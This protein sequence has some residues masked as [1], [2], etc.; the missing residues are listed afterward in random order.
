[1]AFEADLYGH[2]STSTALTG[3]V[4]DRI[5]P[6]RS[7]QNGTT[8]VV[9]YQRISGRRIETLNTGPAVLENL[10]VRFDVYTTAEDT[11]REVADILITTLE[12]ATA[13]KAIALDSP[14]DYYDDTLDLHRRILNVSV[15]A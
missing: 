3:L 4:G 8:P 7:I 2:L 12:A 5:Y 9:V 1:M 11:K 15:W 13:F 14:I 10:H 6:I